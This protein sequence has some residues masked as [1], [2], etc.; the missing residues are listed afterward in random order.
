[1]AMDFILHRLFRNSS[2][3]S[4]VADHPLSVAS[5]PMNASF[6]AAKLPN[7]WTL[8]A[9][10]SRDTSSLHIV[11]LSRSCGACKVSDMAGIGIWDLIKLTQD[12]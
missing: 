2:F 6:G 12:E 7:I 4:Y 1:M 11:L 8:L 3:L 9:I 10:A 5:F